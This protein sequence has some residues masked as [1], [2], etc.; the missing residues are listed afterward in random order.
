MSAYLVVSLIGGALTLEH[1]SSLRF[2]FSQPICSGLILGLALGAPSEGLFVGLMFQ[3]MF[4]GYVH[5]RGE[6]IPDI[7]IGG[8]T[9]SALYI[10]SMRRLGGFYGGTV[11]FLS[12]LLGLLVSLGGYVLY[13]IWERKAWDVSARAMRYIMEGRYRLAARLHMAGLLFHFVLGFVILMVVIPAG[14]EFVTAVAG[15]AGSEWG[16]A[17]DAIR[18]IV[19]FMGAGLL[20]RLYFVRDRTFWFGA[21]FLVT[22]VLFLFRG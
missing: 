18:F 10:L 6:R 11:L 8:I 19:P 2:M 9:S 1:R 3:V 21:G 17:V 14:V 20:A 4:L 13:R 22:Y 15:R 16:E 5:L 12:L 7:P